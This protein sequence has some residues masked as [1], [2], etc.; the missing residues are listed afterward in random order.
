MV[1][2]SFDPGTCWICWWID[3]ERVVGLD[4]DLCAK[5]LQLCGECGQSIGLFHSQRVEAADGGCAMGE[6]SKHR[7][8]LGLIGHI[9]KVYINTMQLITTGD[10]DGVAGDFH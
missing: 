4:G 3:D 1:I 5:F 2:V 6:Q 8:G 9:Q 10:G 7:Q